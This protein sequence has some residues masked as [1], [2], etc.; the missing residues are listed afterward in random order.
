MEWRSNLELH[1]KDGLHGWVLKWLLGKRHVLGETWDRVGEDHLAYWLE[2]LS[3]DHNDIIDTFERLDDQLQI[4]SELKEILKQL[5]LQREG[6]GRPEDG[7]P[8]AGGGEAGGGGDDDSRGGRSEFYNAWYTNL[9]ETYTGGVLGWLM[10]WLLRNVE[11]SMPYECLHEA[12][13][14]FWLPRMKEETGESWRPKLMLNRKG[15]KN[16][17]G[18]A[19]YVEESMSPRW[20]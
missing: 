1:H 2:M 4:E 14:K 19:C 5:R 7:P 13:L 3:D 17:H 20:I 6:E 11:L 8:R 18:T 10:D 15:G 16:V 12:H 9:E